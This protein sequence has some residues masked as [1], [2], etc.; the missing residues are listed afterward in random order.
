MRTN[1]DTGTR[2]SRAG[3]RKNR[4][5]LLLSRAMAIVMLISVFA[6]LGTA[7]ADNPSISKDQ[8]IFL[9][10]EVSQG[11]TPISEGTLLDKEQ[12]IK[13]SFEFRVPVAGDYEDDGTTPILSDDTALLG[14]HHF[15]AGDKVIIPLS[16]SFNLPTPATKDLTNTIDAASVK[17][18]TVTFKSDTDGV[19]AEIVFDV[20][21]AYVDRFNG[22]DGPSGEGPLSGV[23]CRFNAEFTYNGTSTEGPNQER[24]IAI[25]D[26]TFVIE[27]TPTPVAFEIT[28]TGSS[29]DLTK[30]EIEW[31]VTIPHDNGVPVDLG[32]YV[33]S[34]ALN[35][36][37][38]G[39]YVADSFEVKTGTPATVIYTGGTGTGTFTNSADATTDTIG[40]TFPTG[41]STPATIT[42]K[43]KI[44][45]AKYWSQTGT[46]SVTNKAV[47]TDTNSVTYDGE[48]TVTFTPKWI[49]K[50]GDQ[51]WEES[52]GDF[53]PTNP[54][55][56]TITWTIT[57]NH[58]GAT[59]PDAKILDTFDTATIYDSVSAIWSKE[60]NGVW[61]PQGSLTYEAP[62]SGDSRSGFGLGTIDTPVQ[63]TITTVVKESYLAIAATK[64][65]TNNASLAWDSNS[66]GIGT[67][68]VTAGVGYNA[69]SKS[70]TISTDDYRVVDW[71]VNVD[72]KGQAFPSPAVYDLLVYD[73]KPGTGDID[74]STADGFPLGFTITKT[75]LT[76][77]YNQKYQTG[78]FV[79]SFDGDTTT[80]QLSDV[81]TI[82]QGGV[83]VADL[84][85]VE[86]VTSGTTAKWG[87]TFS[88][89][90][91]NP[92]IFASNDPSSTNQI[93][94]TATLFSDN[95]KF[96]V[97]T[98]SVNYQSH[99]LV[100]QM[101]KRD[102]TP[103]NDI[104]ANNST[105]TPTE[106][107]NYQ[108]KSAIFRLV[109]NADK[110]D[111]TKTYNGGE[112]PALGTATLTDILPPDWE[113][114]TIDGS[115]QYLLYNADTAGAA[116]GSPLNPA[117]YGITSQFNNTANPAQATFTF[118]ALNSSYIILVKAK[119]KDSEVD[120]YLGG[121]KTTSDIT[122][123][124]TLTAN[125]NIPV[126]TDDQKV[127]IVSTVVKKDSVQV[128]GG[129][130]KWTID[131]NPYDLDAAG[132]TLRDQLPDGVDLR[133]DSKGDL[134]LT[135]GNITIQQMTLLSNGSLGNPTDITDVGQY[136]DYNNHERTL[137][138][139]IP[140]KDRAYRFTYITE[141]TGTLSGTISNKVF[142][143]DAG[144]SLEDT[145]DDYTIGT[146]DAS[147]EFASRGKI[148]ITKLNGSTSNPLPGAEFTLYAN[149]DGNLGKEIRTGVNTT[150]DG[151]VTIKNI[152]PGNYY[153][154]ETLAPGNYIP[155]DVRHTVIV[156]AAGQTS[157]DGKPFSASSNQ[158]TVKNFPDTAHVGSLTIKKT[159]NVTTP[160]PA[161]TFDFKV[162]FTGTGN[163][164]T[165]DY[166]GIGV[167]SGTIQSGD[168]ITLAHSQSI[169][170]IGLP[171]TLTYTVTETNSQG[172]KVSSTGTTGTIEANGTKTAAF[173][174]YKGGGGGGT[175]PEPEKDPGSLT[176]KKTVKGED[177][178]TSKAFIFTVTFDG[179]GSKKFDYTG[180][181]GASGGTIQSGDTVTLSDGQSIMITGIP[182]D[183]HYTVTESDYAA[184]GYTT[185][186]TSDSGTIGEG[187]FRTASFTNTKGEEPIT[188]TDPAVPTDP[189]DPNLPDT[190]GGAG[191]G[192]DPSLPDTGGGA[193]G[194]GVPKTGDDSADTVLGFG[195]MISVLSLL[196]LAAYNANLGIKRR[197]NNN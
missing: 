30:G 169:T 141:V 114:T 159:L 81:Y 19:Y 17:V 124:V 80:S 180:T 101:L 125:G 182:A 128:V 118:P 173:V 115:S 138:F 45:D 189:T 77:Q 75:D 170:I 178:D 27:P 25:L 9:K 187:A 35:L 110:L 3:V 40:Y 87:F 108:D 86:P 194:N 65:I 37:S 91:T 49:E 192:K 56:R 63:L 155:E 22:L 154:I 119:I 144:G 15:K 103:T 161:L 42:F 61:V 168:T 134:I 10:Q 139:T 53:D 74:L 73:A 143:M 96:N 23:V 166:V 11:D 51:S 164:G 196:G 131:Y 172:Y 195:L 16:S 76:P 88:T 122:N 179:T 191:G 55:H 142:L 70:G 117:D 149:A 121:N 129:V 18:G 5:R 176:I 130:I 106:G 181:G 150:P 95:A 54:A 171:D 57:A 71:K 152:L 157:I 38:T 94:N 188:P 158:L 165:Y 4:R 26:K 89:I 24:I 132:T 184:E 67:G 21:T 47:L 185:T 50:E 90:V 135:G 160:D 136:V 7:Y 64:P 2:T 79:G 62:I 68:D 99:L 146:A 44:P 197:K 34:D 190:D 1:R 105:A 8:L 66:G 133:T 43:T 102:A 183:T 107:F 46:Q 32:N 48:D 93:I 84:L 162:E 120:K 145:H 123:T 33:F 29:A 151:K 69:L 148:I 127:T 92:S 167:P 41:A 60:I 186:S 153:L 177:A 31:T 6:P 140:D 163:A 20:D 36:A 193:G 112:I 109:V 156:N 111:F 100:K 13:L 52:M 147:A 83:P 72:P 97:A 113:F 175:P 85:K 82:T 126:A 137:T 104:G 14:K 116:F 59:L 39:T 78:S 174:N 12:P 28:K 58:N 98:D